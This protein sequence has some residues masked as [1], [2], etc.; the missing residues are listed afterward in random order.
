[1]KVKNIYLSPTEVV[2]LRKKTKCAKYLLNWTIFRGGPLMSKIWQPGPVCCERENITA[3]VV[4]CL[5]EW[6]IEDRV[7]ALCFDTTA[8]N[9]GHRQGAC[10]LIEQHY[11]TD[12]RSSV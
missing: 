4:Q 1:M 2:P 10:V 11:G 8:S 3:A 6:D 5:K 7:A 9:T 12:H